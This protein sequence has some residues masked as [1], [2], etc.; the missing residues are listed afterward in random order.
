M[1]SLVKSCSNPINLARNAPTETEFNIKFIQNRK[2]INKKFPALIL[3]TFIRSEFQ[4]LYV[5]NF[6]EI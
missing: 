4:P 5:K 2:K 6:T 3:E 1:E